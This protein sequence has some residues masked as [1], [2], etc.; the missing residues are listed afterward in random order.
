MLLSLCAGVKELDQ[1]I[2]VLFTTHMFIGGFFGFV[3][4]NTIPGRND[5]NHQSSSW[6][7]KKRLGFIPAASFPPLHSRRF[8]SVLCQ[9]RTKSV[10]SA[11]GRSRIWA[12]AGQRATSRATTSRTAAPSWRGSA[13]PVTCPSFRPSGPPSSRRA[14]SYNVEISRSR[15]SRREWGRRGRRGLLSATEAFFSL[16]KKFFCKKKKK[17]WGTLCFFQPLP[18]L[19]PSGGAV[20]KHEGCFTVYLDKLRSQRVLI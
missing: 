3:L 14:P 19:D 9:V 16:S 1:V 20:V 11:A 18:H 17:V 13:A 2:V 7:R 10:A 12:T 4:D 15:C 5:A 8:C 6:T